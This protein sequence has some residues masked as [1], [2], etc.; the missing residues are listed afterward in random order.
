M[1]GTVVVSRSVA[2]DLVGM[3]VVLRPVLPDHV[4]FQSRSVRAS[5]REP[6]VLGERRSAIVRNSR[7][8]VSRKP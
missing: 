2:V 4:L 6:E 1:K 5:V 7:D 8:F 3:V